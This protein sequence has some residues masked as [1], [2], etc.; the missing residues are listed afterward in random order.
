MKI[1][2]FALAAIVATS[3]FLLAST[4]LA[5]QTPVPSKPSAT[6]TTLARTPWGDPDLQG[7]WTNKTVTPFERP[8]A[9]SGK[10]VLTD[11]EAAQIESDAANARNTDR[12]D[13][14]GTDAD[15]GRAYNEFWWDRGTK[16]V[17]S[18]RTSLVS[19]PADGKVPVKPETQKRMAAAAATRNRPAETWEDRSLYE[20][21]IIRGGS[22]GEPS[23]PGSMG[24]TAYNSNYQIVQ[25][26]GFVV[27]QIEM[28]PH[29]RIIPVDGRAHL[30]PNIHL[31]MGDSRGHWEGNTLVVDSTNFSD[32]DPYKGSGAAMHMVERF[33]RVDANTID[34]QFTIE[35][36]AA[37][38]QPWTA[39][40]PMTKMRE[41]LYEYACHEGNRGLYGIL[42][43]A[44]AQE[45]AAEDAA[46]KGSR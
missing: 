31:W 16:V 27:I 14:A 8:N 38:T 41:P 7:N 23:L 39:S 3:L 42:A 5:A 43:G 10:D 46:K 1:P 44:R 28:V 32:K 12:R 11:E 24:P 4:P 40:I 18:K 45:K 13:G 29:T 36:P 37:F 33:T 21:C 22:A 34:Y 30:D 25:A 2:R 26:P 19:D 20:R 17:G 6:K 35:D 15:V 9:L